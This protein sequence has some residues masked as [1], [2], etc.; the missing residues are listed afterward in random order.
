MIWTGGSKDGEGTTTVNHDDLSGLLGGNNNGHYHF[1]ADEYYALL[2]FIEEYNKTEPEPEPE[3]ILRHD[4]LSG[5]LGGDNNGHYHF[6]A[7]EYYDL[8]TFIE[9]YKNG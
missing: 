2:A 1:T 7:D 6:T 8:L 5:L 9:Q 3:P 4:D